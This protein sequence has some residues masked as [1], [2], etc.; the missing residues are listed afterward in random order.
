[1]LDILL[2]FGNPLSCES[3]FPYLFDTFTS[4]MWFYGLHNW[5]FGEVCLSVALYIYSIEQPGAVGDTGCAAGSYADPLPLHSTFS[6]SSFL[7][8]GRGVGGEGAVCMEY[9]A[10]MLH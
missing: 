9:V 6:S 4:Y 5:G 10:S 3:V 7:E 8:C 1:M 2:L